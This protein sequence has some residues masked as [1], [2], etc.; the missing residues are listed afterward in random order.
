MPEDAPTPQLVTVPTENVPELAAAEINSARTTQPTAP[1]FGRR[2]SFRDIRLQ[3][4][5]EE[6]QQSGVQRLLIENLERADI[7]C[8]RLQGFVGKYH[9]ADKKAAV[10]EEKLKSNIAIEVLTGGGYALGGVIVSYATTLHEGM[11]AAGLVVG[12]VC[13]GVSALAKYLQVRK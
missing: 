6:L 10:L 9:E 5:P 12:V 11:K 13:I 2:P 4:S 8:D 3:M 7:E 1:V